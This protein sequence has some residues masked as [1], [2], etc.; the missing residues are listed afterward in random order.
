MSVAGAPVRAE[1]HNDRKVYAIPQAARGATIAM[2]ELQMVGITVAKEL[3]R[4]LRWNADGAR[5]RPGLR[6]GGGHSSRRTLARNLRRKI[7]DVNEGAM[8]FRPRDRE[9]LSAWSMP[10][11]G[12]PGEGAPRA[13]RG[14]AEGVPRRPVLAP[15][16]SEGPLFD[17]QEP[18]P[19]AQGGD[20]GAS[21]ST[22]SAR[23][24]GRRGKPSGT[25]QAKAPLPSSASGS[26]RASRGPSSG[27]S[28]TARRRS[29]R[30][31]TGRLSYSPARE[32][33]GAFGIVRFEMRCAPSFEVK[34]RVLSWGAMAT[35]LEPA[36]LHEEVRSEIEA[37]RHR[38]VSR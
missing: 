12:A 31:W 29:G 13:R 22:G 33:R 7:F 18:P 15:S 2:T 30:S 11:S 28:G 37:M 19:A 38:Y 21:P 8:I 26:T 35:V 32:L 25:P 34:T 3:G 24:P 17:G 27:A 9:N 36:E 6:E 16:P 1:R 23:S 14:G 10:S 5:P 20:A 4:Y